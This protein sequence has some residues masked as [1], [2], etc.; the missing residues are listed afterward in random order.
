MPWF[1]ATTL[2]TALMICAVRTDGGVNTSNVDTGLW[3]AVSTTATGAGPAIV[4]P[5]PEA[6]R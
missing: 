4:P 3:V 1:L 2:R 6:N 5:A